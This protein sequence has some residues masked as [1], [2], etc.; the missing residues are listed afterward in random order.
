M[1][2]RVLLEICVGSVDDALAAVAKGADRLELNCALTLGGLTPSVGLFAEVRRRVR[3]PIIA[4]VRPRSGGFAYSA[5][6]FEVM[7][8]DATSLLAAGADGLAFGILTAGGEID[9]VRCRQLREVC[10]D[11]TAVFHRAFDVMPDPVVALDCLIDLGFRRV[12]T[13]GQAE[14]A[15]GADTLSVIIRHAAGRIEVLQAGGVNENSAGEV[16]ARTRC[17]QVHAGLRTVGRDP[18]VSARPSIR[19][20]STGSAPE[21]EFDRTDAFAVAALRSVLDR[22]TPAC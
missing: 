11:R 22:S 21:S 12:M 4:M 13:S 16:I 17:D 9:V 6:D 15:A 1:P 20:G 7:V 8:Q 5:A 2:D 14:S 18:S 10:G 3:V 19:F